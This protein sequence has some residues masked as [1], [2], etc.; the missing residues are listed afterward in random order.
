VMGIWF[1]GASVG[2]FL[3]GQ[4]ASLYETMSLP[5]LLTAVAVLPALAGVGMLLAR[6]PLTRLGGDAL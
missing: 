6:K 3:G 5:T 2:N 1:L 4:A